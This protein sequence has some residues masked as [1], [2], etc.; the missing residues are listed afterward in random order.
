MKPV[1][2]HEKGKKEIALHPKSPSTF[3]EEINELLEKLEKR[4]YELFEWRGREDGQDLDDWLTAE[5]ELLKP[6]PLAIDDKEDRLIIRAEVPGFKADELEISL[7]PAML[8]IKGMQ[9]HETEKDE[10]NKLYSEIREKEI[11]RRIALPVNVLPEDAEARLNDGVLEIA[12][13]KAAEAKKIRVAA[14]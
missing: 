7:E 9:K 2:T 5:K 1:L 6:V 4:A 8:T 14:A 12:V 10:K 3:M 11:F 13:A